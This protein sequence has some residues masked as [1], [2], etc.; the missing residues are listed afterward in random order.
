MKKI[1]ILGLLSIGYIGNLLGYTKQEVINVITKASHAYWGQRAVINHPDGP[2]YGYCGGQ[3]VIDPENPDDRYYSSD[4]DWLKEPHFF[5]EQEDSAGHPGVGFGY[6]QAYLATKD[7]FLMRAAKSLG[8]TLVSAQQEN[9]SGGWWYDMGVLGYDRRE[10]SPTF[11]QVIDFGRWVNIF[12]WGGNANV[13]DYNQGCSTFDGVSWLP[14]MFLLRLYQALPQEDPDRDKY[15]QGAK[16]LA[17]TIVGFKDVEDLSGGFKPYGIGGI[18]QVWPYE[19]AKTHWPLP[20]ALG[21]NGIGYPCF[22]T[23]NDGAMMNALFYL[24]EF[25]KE[26]QVNPALNAQTYYDAIV[27]NIEY[28]IQVF[29]LNAND[30]DPLY[31]NLKLGSWGKQF[32]VN[33][34]TSKSGKITWGRMMEPPAYDNRN[35]IDEFLLQ[36]YDEPAFASYK[37][38]IEDVLKRFLMFWRCK[39]EPVNAAYH[40]DLGF[41]ADD[42]FYTAYNPSDVTTWEFWVY[43]NSDPNAIDKNGNPIVLNDWI[44][45]NDYE[46]YAG[47]E[48]FTEPRGARIRSDI[49]TKISLALIEVGGNNFSLDLFHGTD[50]RHNKD[51]RYYFGL[52]DLSK[53]FFNQIPISLEGV[54]DTFDHDTGFFSVNTLNKDGKIYQTVHDRTFFSRMIALADGLNDMDGSLNDSDGDGFSDEEEIREGSD[55]NDSESFPGLPVDPDPEEPDPPIN[56][57]ADPTETTVNVYNNI[58]ASGKSTQAQIHYELDSEKDVKIAVYDSKG[59]E[60]IVLVN[61]KQPLNRYEVYW[62]GKDANNS[63]VGSGIYFVHIDLGGK[64]STKKIAVIK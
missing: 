6:I 20:D 57:E 51:L 25:W 14:G 33:D 26:A 34:G 48:A 1:L 55:I 4:W 41:A 30:P 58:I 44:S 56:P 3:T 12:S 18:P 7:K 27:L 10:G 60:V 61:E 38:A 23:P 40:V 21:F 37:P 63:D 24:L 11:G 32:Y 29:E 46:I 59:R 43:I 5:Q 54:L 16:W 22:V 39:V 50:D 15:L 35:Y 52:S 2:F 19:K 36:I 31:D 47:E 13:Q 17:E 49:R 28:L 62:S 64:K 9:G 53:R 45:A 8:D 42:N